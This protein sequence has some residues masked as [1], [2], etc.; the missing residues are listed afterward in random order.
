M[1]AVLR[2]IAMYL[3]LL[4]LLR[5]SG[6]KRSLAQ[7]TTMDFL[8]LLIIS[9]VTQQALTGQDFSLFNSFVIILTLFGIDI[10]FTL[11]KQ[12]SKRMDLWLDGTP[13]LIVKDGEILRSRMEKA[14]LDEEDIMSAARKHLGLQRLDDIK[15]AVLEKDGGLTVIPW[16]ATAKASAATARV[17][18]RKSKNKTKKE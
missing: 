4:L 10:F 11:I 2:T 3:F 15:Y 8:L 12:R 13:L 9:E 18:T 16:Q 17:S 6:G 14:R 1:D 7:V 5:L